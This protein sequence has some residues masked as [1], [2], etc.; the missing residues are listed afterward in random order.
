MAST[1]LPPP[2]DEAGPS[3]DP[4]DDVFQEASVLPPL[5]PPL[6]PRYD[7]SRPAAPA[8]D[9][10]AATAR[11][12]KK[13]NVL[14]ALAAKKAAEREAAQ[15]VRAAALAEAAARREEQAR[16]VAARKA[17]GSDMRRRTSRGQPVMR[18]RVDQIVAKLQAEAR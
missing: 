4:Y 10:P 13:F 2:V 5:P 9:A 17:R 3:S 1:P 15:A 11:P 7:G 14:E 12:K 16:R 8:T 6:P 18:F